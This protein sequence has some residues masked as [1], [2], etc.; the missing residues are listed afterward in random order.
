MNLSMFIKQVDTLI[1]KLD[2]QQLKMFLHENARILPE[3]DRIGFMER[4]EAFAYGKKSESR[5][6]A[7]DINL[8]RENKEINQIITNINEG[9]F[10]LNEMLNEEYDDWYNGDEEELY[11]EDPGKVLDKIDDICRFIHKCVD[12]EKYMEGAKVGECL[13]TIKVQTIGDYGNN[14]LSISELISE[15][16]ISA[17]FRKTVL[18]ILY[19][20]YHA[21]PMKERAEIIFMI[22]SNSELIDIKLENLFQY[23]SEELEGINEFLNQLIQDLGSRTGRLAELLIKEAISLKNDPVGSIAIAKTYAD[24][25]PGIL[26]QLLIEGQEQ[27]AEQLLDLGVKA[28]ELIDIKYLIRNEVALVTAEYAWILGKDNVAEN[29]Y[30]EAFRSKSSATD[31]LRALLNSKDKGKVKDELKEIL[32]ELSVGNNPYMYEFHINAELAENNVTTNMISMLEFFAGEFEQVL[33]RRM[34]MKEALGWSGTFMKQGIALFTLLL[35]RGEQFQSGGRSMLESVKCYL[36][37]SSQRYEAGYINKTSKSDNEL[38]LECILGWKESV[39]IDD[40]FAEKVI[41]RL[42]K[43]I[44]KRVNGIMEANRRNY[45]GE[46]AAFIAAL[47][48]V[49]ESRGEC[50]EKQR[51]MDYFKKKYPRRSA[52]KSELERYGYRG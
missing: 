21:Y 33:N 23:G 47:G 41:E 12:R 2:H 24:T 46:C 39:S 11:Y 17:N 10:V 6:N 36:D 7:E 22:L 14:Q 4:L 8:E 37:F 45:Y 42:E 50:N 18:E 20:S 51:Y 44:E 48:E 38:M 32:N 27:S 13:T 15:N 19:C 34:N 26:L 1:E 9:E 40:A 28:L 16:L 31:Y 52:F 29:C 5:Q 30:I 43:K 35:Y 3:H 49:R 25:H